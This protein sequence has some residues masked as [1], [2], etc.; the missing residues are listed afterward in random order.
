MNNFKNFKGCVVVDADGQH[1]NLDILK[2]LSILKKNKKKFI[3]NF[4]S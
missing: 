1:D 4:R 2:I 3:F